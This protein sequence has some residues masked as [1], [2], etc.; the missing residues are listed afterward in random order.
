MR[1]RYGLRSPH[2]LLTA[3]FLFVCAIT[4]H[5][6]DKS[7][8]GIAG[9]IKDPLGA[10]IPKATIYVIAHERLGTDTSPTQYSTTSDRYG[11]FQLNVSEG[12]YDA[13]VS[14]AGFS[15]QCKKLRVKQGQ[16][17]IYNLRLRVDQLVLKERADT[18]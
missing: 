13:F 14:A 7:G 9:K 5:T 2:L 15:P 17:L 3:F 1:T 8:T 10:A 4:A 18:F 6:D 11:A 16:L 12:F